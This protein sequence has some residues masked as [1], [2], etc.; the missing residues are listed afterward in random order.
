MRVLYIDIDTLRRD[1]MSCYGYPR[2]TTP[3]LDEIADKGVRFE[4]YY[5]SD[6]PCLPSRSAL[7]SG[8]F[9]IVSGVVGHGGTTADR[10]PYPARDF[11]DSKD[12]N[13][14]HNLFRKAGF[15]TASIS[16]FAERHSAWW[17]NAGFNEIHNE[18]SKGLESGEQIL[19][20]A[21][22]W[23]RNRGEK[24]N[25]YLHLQ[26]WDPHTPYR[27]PENFGRP[28]END[29]LPD[30]WIT[31]EIFEEHLNKAGPHGANEINMYDDHTSPSYP[32]HPGKLSNRDEVKRFI[33]DYDTGIL[34][35][36]HSI[37][38]VFDSLK[39]LNVF[40]DTAI[41]ISSDHGE[42][43]GELGIYGEHATAD[44]PT[45]NI[46][47][48]IKWPGC[49]NNVSDNNLHYN[50][51][52]APTIADLLEVEKSVEWNGQSFA[53]SITGNGPTGRDYLV[54]SQ[55]A[56]VCQ[57][58][59]RFRD[60]LYIKTFHCGFHLFP[61]EMLFDIKNDPHQIHDLSKERKDLCL[62]GSHIYQKWFDEMMSKNQSTVDPM[63]TVLREGGPY[64]TKGKLSGYIERLEKTERKKAAKM[65][66]EKY[67][68]CL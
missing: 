18:G 11:I 32:R 67:R 43:M 19:P 8:M 38:K 51:D 12:T 14:F 53:D 54:L 17:Y 44:H 39:E 49:N 64:H 27:A 23:I 66:K 28:F 10:N 31:P 6:A 52:L 68:E 1:H 7:V 33:D 40:E 30:D 25:W 21:L 24:D 5:C 57:R 16:T 22:D 4:N 58:S 65:L 13:N 34:Y 59:V 35:A 48:I 26:L 15:Y 47:L 41:I 46:P 61:D 42:N 55:M 50:L 20:I 56:H 3:N 62:E 29:K 2:K 9:G 60:Y 36:D 45:C 37:G 63:Q